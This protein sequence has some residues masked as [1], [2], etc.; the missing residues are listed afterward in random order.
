[1]SQRPISA[2]FSTP[3]QP[4]PSVKRDNVVNAILYFRF[5]DR[6]VG[7]KRQVAYNVAQKACSTLFSEH[8]EL[9]M[10]KDWDET[11]VQAVL[12]AVQ[13]ADSVCAG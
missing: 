12:K 8:N 7:K 9:L 13:S 6:R 3:V 5:Q 4:C 2:F 10:S 11:Q 1:M